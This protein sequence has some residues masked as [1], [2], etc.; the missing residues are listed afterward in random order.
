M[1]CSWWEND[2]IIISVFEINYYFLSAF[3]MDSNLKETANMTR[4]YKPSNP[5]NRVYV[6]GIVRVCISLQNAYIHSFIH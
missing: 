4:K 3:L 5:S 1:F 6:F 2:E